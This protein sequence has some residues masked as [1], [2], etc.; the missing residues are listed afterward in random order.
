MST[1]CDA[2]E[3][4]ELANL[5]KDICPKL[6]DTIMHWGKETPKETPE[7]TPPA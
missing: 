5:F 2:E 1:P 7:E 4:D 3:R 6:Y